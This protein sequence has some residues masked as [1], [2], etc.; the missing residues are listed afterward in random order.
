MYQLIL[1]LCIA[2]ALS[3]AQCEWSEVVVADA[4][5]QSESAC[6]VSAHYIVRRAA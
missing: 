4:I 5:Y 6:L 1:N 3:G 2:T